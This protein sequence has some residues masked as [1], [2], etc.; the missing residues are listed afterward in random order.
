MMVDVPPATPVSSPDAS[1]V[2]L[3]FD[4]LH[5]PSSGMQDRVAV[6]P[7][8]IAAI[9]SIAAG[10]PTVISVVVRQVFGN[11]YVIVV[12]PD[13]IPVISPHSLIVA[14]AVLLLVHV[15]SVNALVRIV[16]VPA[17]MADSPIIAEGTAFTEIVTVAD[18]GMPNTVADTV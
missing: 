17:Q 15:P 8:Y 6:V 3:L 11:S 10:A 2:T 14:T 9:P 18:V 5:V 4:A 16:V 7:G 1:I 13:A 12:V